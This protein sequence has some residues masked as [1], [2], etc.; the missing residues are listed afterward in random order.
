MNDGNGVA[1]RGPNH[2][3]PLLLLTCPNVDKIAEMAFTQ[4]GKG[5]N[6]RAIAGIA[7][8]RNWDNPNEFY[9]SELVLWAA[10]KA[11]TPLLNSRFLPIEHL[12][13]RDIL[14]SP[15]VS[16]LSTL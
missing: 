8:G 13:P 15:Y 3:T 6:Q 12:T 14:L 4:E 2:T 10:E 16:E 9:C 5:Y 7:L 11:G 1:W